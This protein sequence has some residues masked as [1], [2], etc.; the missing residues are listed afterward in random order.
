[1]ASEAAPGMVQRDWAEMDYGFDVCPVTK[2]GHIEHLSE[3]KRK[4]N[5]RKEKKRN[6]GVSLSIR[7]SLV[8]ILSTIQVY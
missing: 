7:W 1:V 8:T 6:L 5:K 2:G 3:V 4:E